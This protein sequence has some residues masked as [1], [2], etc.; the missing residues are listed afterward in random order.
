M[1]AQNLSRNFH[2]LVIASDD[3]IK[4]ETNNININ[5]FCK[6]IDNCLPFIY[7]YIYIYIFKKFKKNEVLKKLSNY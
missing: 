5:V 4:L 6:F 1:L 7:I 3:R 2:Q